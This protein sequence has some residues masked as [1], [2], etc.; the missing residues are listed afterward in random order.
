M[1]ARERLTPTN[2]LALVVRR[3]GPPRLAA[4]QSE[5]ADAAEE[6]AELLRQIEE[7]KRRA[8]KKRRRLESMRRR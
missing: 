3:V 1:T 6:E 5:R 7:D 8:D 2:T 4:P